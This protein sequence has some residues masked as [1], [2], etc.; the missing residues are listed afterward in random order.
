MGVLPEHPYVTSR[1]FCKRKQMKILVTG[2]AGF[3]GSHVT[4][5]L[6]RDGHEVC[7]LDSLHDFYSPEIKLL[8]MQPAMRS[9]RFRFIKA[10]ISEEKSV[11]EIFEMFRPELVIHLAARAGIRPSREKIGEY[12]QANVWGTLNVLQ[13]GKRHNV[14]KFV[15][16]SSSSVYGS[17][18]ESPFHEEQPIR[19]PLSPY[20]ATKIAGEHLCYTFSRQ[21][22]IDVIALRLFSVYGERQRPDLAIHKFLRLMKEKKPITVLGDGSSSRDYTYVADVVDGII[23]AAEKKFNRFEIMN[24]GNSHPVT[25]NELISQLSSLT[26]L[27]PKI[28]YSEADPTEMTATHA[29]ISKATRLLDYKPA[30]S[31]NEGLQRM[32]KWIE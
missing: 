25:I 7:C 5:R 18:N 4:E 24:I 23:S 30:V 15:F 13:A 6:L 14:P 31:L 21:N 28:I 22:S 1:H 10:D 26:G 29:D 16:A 11:E 8:N 17:E 12:Y 19:N 3:I 32:L 2:G 9:E 20:A 27:T